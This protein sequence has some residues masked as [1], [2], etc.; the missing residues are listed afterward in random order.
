MKRI[1]VLCAALATALAAAPFAGA[2]RAQS[3]TPAVTTVEVFANSATYLSAPS[4]PPYVLQVYRVDAMARIGRELSIRL[5]G[6][7]EQ[8]KAYMLQQE[9]QI[10]AR[11]QDQIVQAA[12]GMSLAIHYRLN[13]LPAVVINRES[14]IYGVADVQ[15]AVGLYLQSKSRAQR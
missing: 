9:A 4:N 3:A 2:V 12:N 15:H 1:L 6:N 11:Y 5:P 14:V 7:E 13:R 10:R 8:A